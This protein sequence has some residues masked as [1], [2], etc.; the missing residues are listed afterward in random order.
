MAP[1]PVLVRIVERLPDGFGDLRADA[2]AE[3]YRLIERLFEE[4]NARAMR[5]GGEGE[6]L[7]AARTKGTL[8]AVG[9][10][11]HDPVLAGVMR[12]RRFYVRPSFRMHGVGRALAEALVEQPR[13][14]GRPVVVNAAP[15]SAAFWEA[16][17]FVSDLRDG[18]THALPR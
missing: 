18:H 16:L 7:L 10:L 2:S 4:W 8:A 12:L 14:I 9:G 17:G 5:F 6:A 1:P 11:T 3:R 15:G 13:R